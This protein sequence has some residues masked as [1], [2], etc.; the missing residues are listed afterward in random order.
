[1]RTYTQGGV[2]ELLRKRLNAAK[3]LT[4]L[5][6][7]KPSAEKYE[8]LTFLANFLLSNNRCGQH[9]VRVEQQMQH[10]A[11]GLRP[12]LLRNNNKVQLRMFASMLLSRGRKNLKLL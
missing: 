12:P 11:L 6:R 7:E 4:A 9:F 10:A 1:M 3:T 8:A 5:A 2:S